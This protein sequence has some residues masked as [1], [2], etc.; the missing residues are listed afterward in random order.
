[1][2]TDKIPQNAALSSALPR[3]T[4]SEGGSV[5][6]RVIKNMGGGAY[7][8]ALAGRQLRVSSDIPL[9][10]NSTLRATVHLADGKIALVRQ[11]ENEAAVFSAQKRGFSVSKSVG[12]QSDLKCLLSCAKLVL[13]SFFS[14][15]SANFAA[16]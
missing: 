14:P 15:N 11:P 8:V 16:K 6:V 5:F 2:K 1:M 10:E 4:L 7:L 3:G 13:M 9:T 12:C